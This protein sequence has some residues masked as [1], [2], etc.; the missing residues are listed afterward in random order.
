MTLITLGTR[1]PLTGIPDQT[2]LN[3]GNWTV[4]FTPAIIDVNIAQF[5]VYK[6]IVSGAVNTTFNVFV[7]GKLW[8]VGIYGTLNSWDPMQPLQMHPGQ[9]LDFA[10]SDPSSDGT[11]P[12][13]TIWLRYDTHFIKGLA[14]P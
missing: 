7:D 2:G 1:G 5:E 14:I 11:P 12:V 4:Q 3:S 6:M 13:V 9:E 10:Y 8:D